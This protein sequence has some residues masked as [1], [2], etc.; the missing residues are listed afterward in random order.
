MS[1]VSKWAFK[2]PEIS[3]SIS[4]WQHAMMVAGIRRGNGKYNHSRMYQGFATLS[5]PARSLTPEGKKNA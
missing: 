3:F 5:R 1:C 2:R 4:D